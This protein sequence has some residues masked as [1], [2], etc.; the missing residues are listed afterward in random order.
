MAGDKNINIG[1]GADVSGLKTGMNDAAKLVQDAGTKMQTAAK[2]ATTKTEQSFS[3]LRQAYRATARDAYEIALSQ[4]TNS[5][6]FLEATEK[7]GKFKDELDLV[8][9][10]IKAFSSDTPVL[11]SALGVGQGLAGAFAAA[12][13]A[14]A[15]FGGESDKLQEAMVKVQASMALVQGLTALGGLKDSFMALSAVIT[16]RVVPAIASIGVTLSASG[17]GIAVLAIGALVMVYKQ[18][19]DESNKVAEKTRLAEKAQRDYNASVYDYLATDRQK[20][21]REEN[22]RFLALKKLAEDRKKLLDDEATDLNK[23]KF[24]DALKKRNDDYKKV[25]SDIENIEKQHQDNIQE[26][27]KKYEPKNTKSSSSPKDVISQEVNRPDTNFNEIGIRPPIDLTKWGE[28]LEGAKIPLENFVNTARTKYQEFLDETAKFNEAVRSTLESGVENA[29]INMA[30][31]IGNSLATSVNVMEGIG[32]V[33]LEAVGS[34]AIQLGQLAIQTGIAMKAIKISFKNP[35]T[36]IA[37]GIALIALGSFV[38][39]KAKSITSGG[40][41][42][43]NPPSPD[44]SPSNRNVFSGFTPQNNSMVLSTRLIGT[45]LLMSVQ[46]AGQQNTRVR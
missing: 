36:A 38:S 26:I 6:A 21:I 14:M 28:N 40:G 42:G 37:A 23:A 4:G 41:G 24:G 25:L 3:N 18:L 7:A 39:S 10:K 31:S 43:G 46:K 16:T 44:N 9:T 20:E 32:A 22:M 1:V 2:D 13:G 29:F 15:L 19:S 5:A 33:L 17:I 12:Q 45:D 11:T 35:Y 8:N 34:M 30:A 27:R